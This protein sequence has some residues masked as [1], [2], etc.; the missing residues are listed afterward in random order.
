MNSLKNNF[1]DQI[2]CGMEALK[3][4]ELKS[5]DN[6]ELKRKRIEIYEQVASLM[7]KLKELDL[8]LEYIYKWWQINIYS[9]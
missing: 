1:S 3:N 6:V 2:S 8:W 4:N 7:F 9:R 5:G